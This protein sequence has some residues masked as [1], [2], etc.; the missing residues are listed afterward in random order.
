[1]NTNSFTAVEGWKVLFITSWGRFQRRFDHIID[2]LRKHEELIDKEVNARNIVEARKM[3]QE[4][5]EWRQ[6]SLATIS[7]EQDEQ[8]SLQLQG[9]V[10]WLKLDDTQQ[11]ILHDSISTEAL[12]YQETMDWILKNAKAASW[13]R[14]KSETP[15]LWLK[16]N[17]GT[18]KSIISARLVDFLTSAKSSVVIRYFCSYLHSTS[19]QYD[20]ILKSILLQLVQ[21]NEDLVAHIYD[22]Y[23]GKKLVAI[24]VLEYLLR[25]SVEVISGGQQKGRAIHVILDGLDE[26]PEE[27][28]RRLIVLAD[29]LASVGHPCKML[30]S[31]RSSVFLQGKLRRKAIISLTDEKPCLE[32]AITSYA[33]QRLL[34]IRTMLSQLGIGETDIGE[35]ARRIGTKADG[36]YPFLDPKMRF[37]ITG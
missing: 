11:I 37:S 23:V 31:S 14:P 35:I 3:R 9:I 6:K 26:C 33:T 27:T 7:K 21:H 20:E 25:T 16:G 4:L 18:G 30:I 34:G 10:T 28:Q 12:K 5:Q 19:T 1:M 24:P 8:A 29:R 36:K 15:F 2:N 17:P 22:D 32:K 13:L